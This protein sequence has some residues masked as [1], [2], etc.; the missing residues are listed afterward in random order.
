MEKY[1]DQNHLYELA[2]LLML[3]CYHFEIFSFTH[4][5]KDITCTGES[6]R[7]IAPNTQE[8]PVSV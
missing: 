7:D 5:D 4:N 3:A 1:Y 8:I 2:M 6:T